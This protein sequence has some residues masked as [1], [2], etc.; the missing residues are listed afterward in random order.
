MITLR[1]ME[2][3]LSD[4]RA[5]QKWFAEEELQQFVWCD[6]KGEGAVSIE[7]IVEKY[8]GRVKAQTDVFPYFILSEGHAIGF[9]QYYI[10]DEKTIGLDMWIGEKEKRSRGYGTD[11]L[12]QMVDLIH[13]KHPEVTTLF[14]DPV[15]ENIRAVKCYEKAGFQNTGV[16]TDE[17]GAACYMMKISFADEET[18]NENGNGQADFAPV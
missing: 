2:A 18:D 12:R 5:M 17:E 11:A 3:T 6:E 16:F 14:I 10:Q 7:R 15:V 13:K 8:G 1:P 4:Y 9:I